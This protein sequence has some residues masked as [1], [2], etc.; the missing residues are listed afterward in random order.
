[1]KHNYFLHFCTVT[2]KRPS[3]P[4]FMPNSILRLLQ[5]EMKHSIHISVLRLWFSFI[6][7]YIFSIFSICIYTSCQHRK[8]RT[9]NL[10]SN[11]LISW[12]SSVCRKFLFLYAIRCVKFHFLY[13]VSIFSYSQ[14]GEF[15]KRRHWKQLNWKSRNTL[16]YRL[17]QNT[18]SFQR[19]LTMSVFHWRNSKSPNSRRAKDLEKWVLLCVFIYFGIS[20]FQSV[21]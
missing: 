3:K 12:I 6:F 21:E 11:L 2:I 19:S 9:L 14:N 4:A 7:K 20:H 15:S 8:R 5:N 13:F 17:D 10:R 1:M 18:R 16:N